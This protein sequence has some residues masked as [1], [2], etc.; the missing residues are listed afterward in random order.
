MKLD[1][2]R[3]VHVEGAKHPATGRVLCR[4][5]LVV[6]VTRSASADFGTVRVFGAFPADDYALDVEDDTGR[7]WHDPR[8]CPHDGGAS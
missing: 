8:E 7:V 5:A 2:G 1:V 3:I 4:A 6:H